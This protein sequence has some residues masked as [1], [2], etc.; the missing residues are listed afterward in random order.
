[1]DP[2]E[3]KEFETNISLL[4]ELAEFNDYLD[5]LLTEDNLNTA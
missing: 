1:M 5:F 2:G 3:R 4:T